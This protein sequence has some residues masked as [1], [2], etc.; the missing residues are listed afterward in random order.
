VGRVPGLVPRRR[1]GRLS[2]SRPRLAV[3]R[4]RPLRDRS[5]RM[6]REHASQRAGCGEATARLAAR[7]RRPRTR[8]SRRARHRRRPRDRPGR[9][10]A[11]AL[12]R[13]ERHGDPAK[14]VGIRAVLSGGADRAR[15][16]RNPSWP[17]DGRF[18]VYDDAGSLWPFE[19]G[20]GRGSMPRATTASTTT[21]TASSMPTMPCVSRSGRTGSS[22]RPVVSAESSS[23]S[24]APA[25]RFV[26]RRDGTTRE[27]S[28]ERKQR[29]C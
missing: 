19:P 28:I 1:G 8:E 20:G 16:G 6:L 21:A 29:A 14:D 7:L 2:R 12:R 11:R 26:R 15:P 9:R 23:F 17:P 18:L 27:R 4:V 22:R 5:V 24:T 25:A 10:R 13:R 3:R